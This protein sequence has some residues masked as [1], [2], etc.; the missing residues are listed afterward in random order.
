MIWTKPVD[1]I[2]IIS[3]ILMLSYLKYIS[4]MNYHLLCPLVCQYCLTIYTLYSY[5]FLLFSCSKITTSGTGLLWTMKVP[6]KLDSISEIGHW[7]KSAI[8]LPQFNFLFSDRSLPTVF[9]FIMQMSGLKNP[10]WTCLRYYFYHLVH[11]IVII[12]IEY[13]LE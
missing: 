5:L 12:D 11:P 7:N 1:E 3:N 8:P 10:L 4:V 2:N 9:S 6:L 13:K